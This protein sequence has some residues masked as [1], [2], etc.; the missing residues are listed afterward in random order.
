MSFL[1]SKAKINSIINQ[2]F[3]NT[4][5][6]DVQTYSSLKMC[7][8]QLEVHLILHFAGSFHLVQ[9]QNCTLFSQTSIH[10]FP[11][12]SHIVTL[13]NS[14]PKKIHRHVFPLLLSFRAQIHKLFLALK[15][16]IFIFSPSFSTLLNVS[17]VSSPSPLFGMISTDL[18]CAPEFRIPHGILYVGLVRIDEGCLKAPEFICLFV[19]CFFFDCEAD[20]QLMCGWCSSPLHLGRGWLLESSAR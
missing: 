16:R 17:M 13:P 9:S 4:S 11:L 6:L 18:W 19:F 15:F 5:T 1:K 7:L 8:N 2:F 20:V 3:L 10:K 12:P 14:E